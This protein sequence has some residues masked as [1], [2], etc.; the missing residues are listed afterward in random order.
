MQ[1]VAGSGFSM[2]FLDQYFSSSTVNIGRRFLGEVVDGE[3]YGGSD[4]FIP[5]H[6]YGRSSL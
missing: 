5:S 3:R 4:Q 1:S 6:R 2:A